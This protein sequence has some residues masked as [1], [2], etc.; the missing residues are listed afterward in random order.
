MKK[1]EDKI[2]LALASAAYSVP[3][4]AAY[5]AEFVS[6]LREW[7]ELAG[8]AFG[9]IGA[10]WVANLTN[11]QN[12][13]NAMRQSEALLLRGDLEDLRKLI[14]SL[15]GH[16]VAT[17]LHKNRLE[18]AIHEFTVTPDKS[19]RYE[20]L[21]RVDQALCTPHLPKELDIYNVEDERLGFTNAMNRHVNQLHG[22][23]QDM[24]M[25]VKNALKGSTSS[26]SFDI[27]ISKVG[28]LRVGCESLAADIH[29]EMSAQLEHEQAVRE[30]YLKLRQWHHD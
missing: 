24:V 18:K 25:A 11:R 3:F 10:F 20:V 6:F 15:R 23:Q 27:A 19:V 13:R 16:F 14:D 21:R 22:L 1:D 12:T 4:L 2:V 17:I 30:E 9:V 26:E 29:K 5:G 8:G 7:K 28:A